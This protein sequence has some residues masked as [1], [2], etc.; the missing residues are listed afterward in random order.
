MITNISLFTLWVTDQ[1]AA[2]NF[3]VDTLGFVARADVTMGDGYRWVTVAHPEHP[4]LEVTLMNPGP[5]LD[6][7][8]ASAVRRALAASACVPTTA[9]RA[10]KSSPR[11]ASNSCN[12]RRTA[13]T[14]SKQ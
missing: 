2:K 8:M 1:D 13:R 3:Y 5:P 11:R 6:E 10:T 7:D 4:E 14:A 9:R 12:R